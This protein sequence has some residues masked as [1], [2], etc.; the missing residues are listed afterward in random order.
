MVTTSTLRELNLEKI[1]QR[2]L[3]F[4]R[5]SDD[6]ISK[7]N[8]F[9]SI[10]TKIDNQIQFWFYDLNNS[11]Q[12]WNI[13]V[14]NNKFMLCCHPSRLYKVIQDW[15]CN[16]NLL[17]LKLWFDSAWYIC[18]ITESGWFCKQMSRRKCPNNSL[19]KLDWKRNCPEVH[20]GTFDSYS[21]SHY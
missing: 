1:I 18:N 17:C 15:K 11:V 2:R 3:N 8:N 16:W 4:F 20:C 19:L 6:E 21:Q 9:F 12:R 7:S 13:K 5:R 14:K 10:S